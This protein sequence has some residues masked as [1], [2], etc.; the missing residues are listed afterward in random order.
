MGTLLAFSP[1]STY[2]TYSYFLWTYIFLLIFTL[3]Y[4][5]CFR[6][7]L[8]LGLC[9]R[10]KYIRSPPAFWVATYHCRLSWDMTTVNSKDDTL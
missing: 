5:M 6:F 7:K 4:V 3:F 9:E 2:V 1:G 8:P 10:S